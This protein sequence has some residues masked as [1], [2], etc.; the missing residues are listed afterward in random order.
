MRRESCL[1]SLG[2]AGK[3]REDQ[4]KRNEPYF[5]LAELLSRIQCL[6]PSATEPNIWLNEEA[7][8]HD[9]VISVKVAWAR[10]EREKTWGIAFGNQTSTSLNEKKQKKQ[11]QCSNVGR[12]LYSLSP[13]V[14]VIQCHWKTCPSVTGAAE[15][16]VLLRNGICASLWPQAVWAYQVVNNAAQ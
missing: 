12:V 3:N 7:A 10:E 6:F 2:K 1:P 13:H 8:E 14:M 15:D 11:P 16:R 9:N 4:M 5:P